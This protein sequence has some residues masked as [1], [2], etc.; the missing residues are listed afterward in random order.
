MLW[1]GGQCFARRLALGARA[2]LVVAGSSRLLRFRENTRVS[3]A[4]LEK[5]ESSGHLVF[6]VRAAQKKIYIK[7]RDCTYT[8]VSVRVPPLLRKNLRRR[9]AG[10][11]LFGLCEGGVSKRRLRRGGYESVLSRRFPGAA[12]CISCSKKGT[13]RR[14]AFCHFVGRE[15]LEFAADE[16]R[17]GGGG[18]LDA[19]AELPLLLQL[20]G[21]AL[22]AR[23]P[24]GRLFFPH[25][26]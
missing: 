13:P 11:A 24:H 3:R 4:I 8:A 16:E 18:D 5:R 1:S 2:G 23:E 21:S 15:G 10:R 22:E 25:K 17:A 19:A 9:S 7:V 12:L 26:S 14:W 6:V 20:R